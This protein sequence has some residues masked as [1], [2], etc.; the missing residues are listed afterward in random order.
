MLSV[1][2]EQTEQTIAWF[3]TSV[4]ELIECQPGK[5][6]M[7]QR[8]YNFLNESDDKMKVA[9]ISFGIKFKMNDGSDV[10]NHLS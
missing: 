8:S 4:K 3:T 6:D 9:K 5:T 2:E 7:Y 1:E 10:K